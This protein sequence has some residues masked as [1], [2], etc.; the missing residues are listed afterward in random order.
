MLPKLPVKVAFDPADNPGT[1][2]M[3]AIPAG[4][5][6][7]LLWRPNHLCGADWFMLAIKVAKR[8]QA[9]RPKSLEELEDCFEPVLDVGS[10]PEFPKQ[11]VQFFCAEAIDFF[12]GA[13][14]VS[15]T[16]EVSGLASME[17]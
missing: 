17:G 7:M 5:L 13:D 2:P 16:G 15:Y 4:R 8:I 10:F 11:D 14:A 1:A 9:T 6:L 12:T 3:W